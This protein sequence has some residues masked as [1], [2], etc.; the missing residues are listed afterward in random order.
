MF[1]YFAT[2]RSYFY[3]IWEILHIL[4]SRCYTTKHNNTIIISSSKKILF[5][6]IDLT[7]Y[8]QNPLNYMSQLDFLLFEL[9]K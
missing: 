4:Q 3:I 2:E 1:S 6:T 9:I 5:K 8:F 7:S